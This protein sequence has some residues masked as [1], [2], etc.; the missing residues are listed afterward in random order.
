MV[1]KGEVMSTNDSVNCPNRD[2]VLSL[3][4]EPKIKIESKSEDVLISDPKLIA[5]NNE[6]NLMN[7]VV[8][9]ESDNETK[10]IADIKAKREERKANK[11][12]HKQEKKNFQGEQKP[13]EYK[14]KDNQDSYLKHKEIRVTKAY[15]YL[16]EIYADGNDIE[17]FFRDNKARKELKVINKNVVLSKTLSTD[18]YLIGLDHNFPKI[19]AAL[20]NHLSSK[21]DE[22]L[23]GQVVY[24]KVN[25]ILILFSN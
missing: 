12:K 1:E 22:I 19:I 25:S 23:S 3:S 17:N 7:I 10:R 20:V 14:D 15:A 16:E 24:S 4:K 6:N 21:V 13:N 11:I 8:A 5:N 18:A 9:S 2:S